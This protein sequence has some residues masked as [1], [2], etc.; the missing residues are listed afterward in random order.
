MEE[1]AMLKQILIA[2]LAG[3]ALCAPGVAFA[4]D[5]IPDTPYS[6]WTDAEKQAA[7]ARLGELAKQQCMHYADNGGQRGAFEAAACVDAMFVNHLPA[8]YPNLQQFKDMARDNYQK[9]KNMGSVMPEPP[10]RQ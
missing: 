7:G 10:L 4:T 3:A 9:A 5:G 8:D 6:T 1:V 2:V